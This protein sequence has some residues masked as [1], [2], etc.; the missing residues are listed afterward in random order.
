MVTAIGQPDIRLSIPSRL[1]YIF[2]LCGFFENL[3]TVYQL[4]DEVKFAIV[5]AVMEVA[6]NAIQ[7]GNQM[8]ESKHV[9][10]SVE[11]RADSIRIVCRDYGNGVFDREVGDDDDLLPEDLFATR[12]RG[13]ALMRALMDIVEFDWT[14][15]GTTVTLTK[16]RA[17][18]DAPSG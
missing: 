6:T 4:D 7:H 17:A 15:H 1:D 11:L 3:G 13:I 12:G 10:L 16:H 14:D 8:D 9:D 2:A 5:T 18:Q